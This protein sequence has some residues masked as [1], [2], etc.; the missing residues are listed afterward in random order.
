MQYQVINFKYVVVIIKRK[1]DK[2]LWDIKFVKLALLIIEFYCYQK[3]VKSNM[4]ANKVTK[5]IVSKKQNT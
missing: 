2:Y 3:E 4:N 5:Y 1:N